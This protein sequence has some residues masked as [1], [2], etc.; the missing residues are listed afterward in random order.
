[1]NKKQATAYAVMAIYT[2]K[3]SANGDLKLKDIK[4]LDI[5]EE[6]KCMYRLYKLQYIVEISKR[7]IG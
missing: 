5:E 6:M 2:L 4:L 1:M 3:N 7:K